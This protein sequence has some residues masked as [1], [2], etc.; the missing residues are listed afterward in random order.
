VAEKWVTLKKIF[1]AMTVL[2]IKGQMLQLISEVDDKP[3]LER[4]L[5]FFFKIAKKEGAE[6]WWDQL[7]LEQQAD[8]DLAMIEIDDPKNLVSHDEALS[9][10]KKWKNQN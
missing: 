1:L 3:T 9:F 6:D 5:Q 7:S 4:M 8:L 10:L 2:E